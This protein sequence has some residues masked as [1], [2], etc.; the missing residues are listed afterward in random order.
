MKWQNKEQLIDLLATLVDIPS[1]TGTEDEIAFPERL[2]YLLKELT[3]FQKHEELLELHPT[4]DGRK[5][6]T[7]LVKKEGARNT[8]ILLS[9]FDVVD[10]EDYGNF[11]PLAFRMKE[12]TNEYKRRSHNLQSIT[13]KDIENDNEEWYFGRGTM[14]MKSGLCLHLSMIEQA[15]KGTFD[16]NLLL[17]TVPDEEVNSVGMLSA[18][19]TLIHLKEKHDL[20]YVTCLNSEPMFKKNPNDTNKYLYSGSIGKLLPSFFCLGMETHVGEPFSGLNANFMAAKLT[21]HFELNADFSEKVGDEISPPPTNLIQKDFKEQYSVQTPHSAVTMFN[22]FYMKTSILDLTAKLLQ[23]THDV[24]SSIKKQYSEN[25]KR[26]LDDYNEP[27]IHV[28]T[29]DELLKHA[30]DEHG[31]DEI[32]RRNDLLIRQRGDLGD[33]DFST[34]FVKDLAFLCKDRGP[35]IILFYS[36]PFYPSVSSH[37]DKVVQSVLENIIKHCKNDHN[38]TIEHQHYFPGMSDLSFVQLNEPDQTMLHLTENI[39][40][41][42]KGYSLP[43]EGM[44]S[45]NVPVMNIGPFGRA[46]HQRTERVE[47]TFTFGIL[48]GVMSKA[49]QA[50]FESN[51]KK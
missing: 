27:S 35:M 5:F 50:L 21:E 20:R 12:L 42:N 44:K 29:Y 38:I 7:S 40:I 1:I 43:I 11:K 31:Q 45:L 47:A 26:L 8:I 2:F 46:P 23:H 16:G 24:V 33:R 51:A 34:L 37:Q 17:V 18:I 39:P 28:Y 6:L 15:T 14:D 36:P 10:V 4:N 32:N 49:I 3:Y 30:I 41:F 13:K 48:P 9:H 22:L 25:A 19:D